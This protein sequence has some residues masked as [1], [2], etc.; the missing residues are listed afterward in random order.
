[1]ITLKRLEANN[2]KSLRS[3]TLV[4]P[5][6]GTVLIEGHNEAGKSTLFEAVYVALY[7]KPLV[8]EDKQ[9]RQEEV[10]QHGQSHTMVQLT[11]SV[12]QQEVTISRHF[13]RG[14]SQ[15]ANLVIQ[16]PG[17]QQEEVNRVR[18]VDERILKELG[19]L[20]G[21]SLRN[22]CFVEQKEL[23]RIEA[24]SLDQRKQ[25][26]QK[27][28]GLERL[29]QLMEQFKFR[30]EQ[31]RELIL[32]QSYLRLA[33][34]QAEV[35]TASAKETEL[36]ERL[37]AVKVAIQVKRLTDLEKQKEEIEKRLI[38]CVE[39]P[40][41]RAYLNDVR[42]A[43]EAVAQSVQARKQ[44][45]EAQEASREAE[46]SVKALEQAE[47]D[48]Q[49]KEADLTRAQERVVQRHKEAEVEQQ[50]FMQKLSELE[51]K[52]VHLVDALALVKQ[53]E[54]ANRALLA[55]RQEISIAE[56]KEQAL[57]KLQNEMRQRED[58]VRNL[59]DAVTLAEREMMQ[60][61]EAV[62]LA[63]AYEALTAWT[64]L[65]GVEMA[66]GGYTTQHT[67]LITRHQEAEKSVAAARAKARMPCIAGIALTVLAALTLILGFLWLP[68]FIL[69]VIFL[70][71]AIAAWV[72]YFRAKKNMQQYSEAL[73][74]W[75]QELQQLDMQ[76]QAAIQVGGD[77]VTLNQY[78]QQILASGLAVPSSLEAG[79]SL[80]ERLRQQPGTMQ[81]H[82]TLQ[83][84]AQTARDTY[85][86]FGEQLKLAQSAA[87]EIRQNC[88]LL[89]NLAIRW[90]NWLN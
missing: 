18:A 23:G 85:V 68:A 72:G 67:E 45:Q 49:Q 89:N 2:F 55:L 71:G 38:E 90:N 74:H 70:V 36:A 8:G 42:S 59:E 19:N 13:E 11:F 29:T 81:G 15:Q 64:R 54:A 46:R 63:T 53:W 58:D 4:F 33:E 44:V 75:T 32:A 77:P 82:H 83:E 9:A 22:S 88:I 6:H 39:L 10:I 14:K 84:A 16:R 60:A 31:E 5:E 34:L 80:Q 79:H 56:E 24:L 50:G 28:L 78:E 87:E 1:M 66:L 61:T 57:L 25:A 40:Q 27:L 35:R 76:R 12:G 65:K 48:Q 37:D 20:D 52:R 41:A 30:R 26:I 51:A 17:A 3:V 62:R 7:G 21:D 86:R 69:P 73:V 43:A 47:A